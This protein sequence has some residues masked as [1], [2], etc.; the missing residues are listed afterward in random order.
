MNQHKG[1]LKSMGILLVLLLAIALLPMMVFASEPA[2]LYVGGE[3]AGHYA[4][5]AEAIRHVA[6][7]NTQTYIVITEAASAGDGITNTATGESHY[8]D[9]FISGT[10]EFKL[11]MHTGEI[12]ITA[13]APDADATGATLT[14]PKTLHISGKTTLKDIEVSGSDT[15]IYSD[16]NELTL[17]TGVTG[18]IKEIYLGNNTNLNGYINHNVRTAEGKLTV[19]SGT[20]TTIYGGSRAYHTA[21]GEPAHIMGADITIDGGT[22]GTLYA[23]GNNYNTADAI[24]SVYYSNIHDGDIKVTVN[25]GTITSL[26]GS[27]SWTTVNGSIYITIN[28]G[29]ISSQL[30]GAY[31]S[32]TARIATV[33][34]DVNVTLNGGTLSMLHGARN[35]NA[36]NGNVNITASGGTTQY[37]YGVDSTTVAGDLNITAT[38][39]TKVVTDTTAY[40]VHNGGVVKGS[41]YLDAL[42]P[43]S[44]AL[45]AN[46]VYAISGTGTV[47]KDCVVL[48]TT[49]SINY[50]KKWYEFNALKVTNGADF[51]VRYPELWNQ[52]QKVIISDNSILKLHADCMNT[53]QVP[54]EVIPSNGE[55]VA[56]GGKLFE[57]RYTSSTGKFVSATSGYTFISGKEGTN[58]TW[59]LQPSM[60]YNMTLTE[61]FDANVTVPKL[62]ADYTVWFQV[63]SNTPVQAG[64]KDNGAHFVSLW[65]YELNETITITLKNAQN[66]A[67]VEKT[68]D[69]DKYKELMQA[70]YPEAGDK[71]TAVVEAMKAYCTHAKVYNDTGIAAAD[72]AYA[73]FDA[74]LD[75]Y[76][77][78]A[79]KTGAG[80]KIK[81]SLG[82]ASKLTLEIPT[83]YQGYTLAVNEGAGAPAGAVY[84]SGNIPVSQWGE[85]ITLDFSGGDNDTFQFKVC[86]LG[87]VKMNLGTDNYKVRNLLVAMYEYYTAA[88]AT[89]QS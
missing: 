27:N 64:V 17:D 26:F 19:K 52:I 82:T 43:A 50:T 32:K 11:P 28:G 67:A 54:V 37:F 56:V 69:L 22:I 55:A 39:D 77:I 71:Y 4:T 81:M 20:V 5:L 9:G 12:I 84:Y 83:A 76:A 49:N 72:N 78:E 85:K 30:A 10:T 23:S 35:V 59:T 87:Y 15:T 16:Y 46:N 89:A 41:L 88:M 63:G 86:P 53:K 66:E 61:K 75:E 24:E 21:N 14:L 2:V 44:G 51:M 73:E 80:F 18:T 3:G 74:S 68:V 47:E 13:K 29:A 79:G 42:Q 60:V 38:S 57:D 7:D 25:G 1:I 48:S 40:C 70:Q 65:P 6:D 36:V 31:A 62:P 45:F 58:I 8:K 34:G 33:S